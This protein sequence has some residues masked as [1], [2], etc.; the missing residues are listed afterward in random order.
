M[1]PFQLRKD[2]GS[3]YDRWEPW[4]STWLWRCVL[5]INALC[6]LLGW[7]HDSWYPR[8]AAC[9]VF[10]MSAYVVEHFDVCSGCVC[11]AEDL[12]WGLWCVFLCWRLT[13]KS[14][15]LFKIQMKIDATG[16][17]CV[18]TFRVSAMY[19]FNNGLT[20]N[21]QKTGNYRALV[22]VWADLA[23]I[24]FWSLCK[25]KRCFCFC[26]GAPWYRLITFTWW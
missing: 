14:W 7:N 17:W 23:F 19:A 12:R 3:N 9:L 18:D 13:L 21:C 20:L 6:I 4:L 25:R 10:K 26:G 15:M 5:D 24:F 8:L 2:E 16:L 22:F 1:F 11:F